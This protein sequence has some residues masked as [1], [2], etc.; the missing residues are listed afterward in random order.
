M[1]FFC[2]NDIAS[3]LAEIMEPWPWT[4]FPVYGHGRAM[5]PLSSGIYVYLGSGNQPLYIGQTL[6]LYNRCATH[7][8]IPQL[9]GAH[10]QRVAWYTCNRTILR[11]LEAALIAHWKPSLNTRRPVCYN[12][13]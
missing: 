4:W 1:T 8:H 12:K 6:N 9:Y 3:G 11:L 13:Q 2:T 7:E 10:C 5:L